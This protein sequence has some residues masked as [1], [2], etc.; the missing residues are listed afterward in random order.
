MIVET[1]SKK[2]SFQFF[3]DDDILENISLNDGQSTIWQKNWTI[4]EVLTTTH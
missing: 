3:E 2:N 4:T 1:K